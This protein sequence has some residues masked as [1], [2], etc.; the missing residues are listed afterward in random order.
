MLISAAQTWLQ[1]TIPYGVP[2]TYDLGLGPGH[3]VTI[4]L[5]DANHCPG[6]TM[7]VMGLNA[8]ARRAASRSTQLLTPAIGS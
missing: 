2:R 1:E 8:S 7:W 5:I 3:E 6:S 4:T